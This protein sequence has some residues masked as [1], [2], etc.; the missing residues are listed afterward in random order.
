[1]TSNVIFVKDLV[2]TYFYYNVIGY[3]LVYLYI[4]HNIQYFVMLIELTLEGTTIEMTTTECFI[5]CNQNVK[6]LL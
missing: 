6:K 4:K 3:Y 2:G 1:M 5:P